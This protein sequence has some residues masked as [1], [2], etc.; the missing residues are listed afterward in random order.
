MQ[1][2]VYALLADYLSA[3]LF[4]HQASA[5][6]WTPALNNAVFNLQ[7]FMFMCAVQQVLALNSTTAYRSQAVQY[8]YI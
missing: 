2:C 7:Q 3:C 8:M 4:G 1:A 6:R 5:M